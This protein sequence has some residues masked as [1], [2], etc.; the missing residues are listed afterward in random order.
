[1]FIQHACISEWELNL[2]WK[3]WKVELINTLIVQN[4]HHKC[5]WETR[6]TTAK[7][8]IA[9]YT[10]DY[11][12]CATDCNYIVHV[13][14][15]Y[16]YVCTLCMCV[17]MFNTT[18]TPVLARVRSLLFWSLYNFTTFGSFIEV[19]M[20]FIHRQTPDYSNPPLH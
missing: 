11:Y 8:I 16:L 6:M 18:Y 15:L 9:D 14:V 2:I 17:C 10:N 4:P 1:M 7:K 3:H 20:L 12:M 5:D 13:H 19:L